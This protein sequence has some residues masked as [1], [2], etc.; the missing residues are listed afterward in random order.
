[1]NKTDG[2]IYEEDGSWDGE[3]LSNIGVGFCQV[4]GEKLLDVTEFK[5]PWMVQGSRG[6]NPLNHKN[7]VKKE[8]LPTLKECDAGQLERHEIKPAWVVESCMRTG[9][10]KMSAGQVQRLRSAPRHPRPKVR[11][12]VPTRLKQRLRN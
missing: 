6:T 2:V 7:R 5:E 10:H 11:A 8:A 3:V 12:E 1:M 9:R 4:Q